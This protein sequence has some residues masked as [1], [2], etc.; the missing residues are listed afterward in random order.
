MKFLFRFSLVLFRV[1]LTSNRRESSQ[2]LSKKFRY[3]TS[4]F[5][6]EI[7]ISYDIQL[8]CFGTL[9]L[10]RRLSTGFFRHLCLLKIL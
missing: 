1:K 3:N 4:V 9:D 2:F 5:D 7:I 10:F 6:P 8:K